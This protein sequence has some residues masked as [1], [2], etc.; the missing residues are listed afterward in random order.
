MPGAGG[1]AGFVCPPGPYAESPVPGG[2]SPARVAGVPPSDDFVT[3]DTD[4]IIVEGPVWF[5]GN[6]YVSEINN[7]PPFGPGFP[8]GGRSGGGGEPGSAGA[9][10]TAGSGGDSGQPPPA[11]I[12]RITE[13]GDVSIALEDVGTNGLAVSPDGQLVGCSHKTGSISR[14]NLM[15]GAPVDIVSQYESVRFDSPNDLTFG[16]DGTLYFTD[17]D[18]QAPSPAPQSASRAYRV[19]PGS[20][21]AV[22]LLDD[23]PRP[24]G[25]TLS[26]DGKTLYVSASDGV[27]AYPVMA[28][29]NIGEGAPFGQGT[30]RSS[31]GMGVDCAG[32]LYTTSGQTVTVLTPAGTELTRISVPDAQQV[33][34]VAFGGPSHTTLYITAQGSGQRSGLF[35]LESAIPGMPY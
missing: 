13:A 31:D 15:G 23:R 12:L 26:P 11:R 35:K 17:P 21:T 2:A 4:L 34:N 29:G 24:N 8:G 22:A 6:L 10:G 20:G 25:I 27:Y 7:G 32:N 16:V 1:L 33:T 5:D 9:A 3:D 30:V 14:F 19:P 28:D 18:Y